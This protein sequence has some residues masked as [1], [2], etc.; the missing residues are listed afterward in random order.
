MS[1]SSFDLLGRIRSSLASILITDPVAI[2][3][4]CGLAAYLYFKRFEP[5]SKFPLL[6]LLILIPSILSY[7]FASSLV[8]SSQGVAATFALYYTTILL[9][10]A[11]YRLSPW[12]PLAK[13]PGPFLARLSKFWLAAVA[14]RGKQHVNL[15]RLH[16]R[17][18]DVV[19]IGP[20]DLSIRDASIIPAVLG[21]GGLS[22]GPY[23]DNRT[24]P[25]SL[26]VLRDAAEHARARKSWDRAFSSKALKE[27]DVLVSHRVRQLVD[28]L[29]DMIKQQSGITGKL[30]RVIDVSS[31]ITFFATDF[32][33]DMAFGGGFELMADRGDKENVYTIITQG[34][35]AT[36]ILGHISWALP[37]INS[38]APGVQL[39][40]TFG[41][42]Q[43][44]R[45]LKMDANRK[46]LYYYLSGEE[47]PE[48]DRPPLS[49]VAQQGV[50]SIVAGSDTTST[51]S[52]ALIHYLVTTPTAYERLQREVDGAFPHD[53]EPLD[54]SKLS[55]LE[56]LNAC[57]NEAM[58]LQPAVPGGSHR[59][60]PRGNGPRR[61][62]T[63]VF[64]EQT[65][66][67]IHTYSVQRD[68]R[69]F[70]APDAFEPQRWIAAERLEGPHNPRAFIPFSYGPTGCA[71]K[72]LALMEL[73]MLLCWLLR[74]FHFSAIPGTQP[75]TWEEGL[76]D[77][78]VLTRDALM[79]D[80][81]LRG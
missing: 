38:L 2:T 35:T 23:W 41:I 67:A 45:R 19:R 44:T 10:T 4:H 16:E 72:S 80:V 42:E 68:P 8:S 28:H 27:Y 39:L 65:Q 24:E 62:G 33:G 77:R 66:L 26:V 63:H 56:W 73:R 17:Y 34:M 22:K 54:V 37:V 46:D 48:K 76:K 51:T 50:L 78:F 75:G 36:S 81:S 43:V 15:K 58:R 9:S 20:N 6:V 32:M 52:T 61:F 1:V 59:Y 13:Y 79:L 3:S 7:G 29:E 21:P 25:D 47:L 11:T 74:R 71:G 53:E 57:I 31:W 12:H 40:A 14:V 55:E 64:P 5:A 49:K 18:G 60:I 70:Y 69:N 30:S